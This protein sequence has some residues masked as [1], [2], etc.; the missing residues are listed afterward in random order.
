MDQEVDKRD[1]DS[2]LNREIKEVMTNV[3][4]RVAVNEEDMRTV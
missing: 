2:E 3:K 1:K 4:R